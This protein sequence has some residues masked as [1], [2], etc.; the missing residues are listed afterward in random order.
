M[1]A[2]IDTFEFFW[3]CLIAFSCSVVLGTCA[4]GV[5]QL[6]VGCHVTGIDFLA[7]QA[8]AGIS[9]HS[10]GLGVLTCY[11]KTLSDTLVSRFS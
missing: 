3:V 6:A 1:N 7:L 10:S 4:T 8:P 9:L 11:Y 5:I 2:T